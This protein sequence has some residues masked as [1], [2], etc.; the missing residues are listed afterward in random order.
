MTTAQVSPAPNF[1]SAK[2][3]LQPQML[4]LGVQTDII[5]DN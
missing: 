5:M 1:L 2:G 3:C 4:S